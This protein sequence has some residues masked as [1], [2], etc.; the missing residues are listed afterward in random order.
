M[1]RVVISSHSEA[2]VTRF[3]R[4]KA[5]LIDPNRSSRAVAW[6]NSSSLGKRPPL[7]WSS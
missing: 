1:R 7:R 4:A 6:G 5:R 3:T 2:P